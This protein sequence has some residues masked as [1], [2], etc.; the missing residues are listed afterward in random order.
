M[1][2]KLQVRST[3]VH[4]AE[5]I[6]EQCVSRRRER[7]CPAVVQ[8]QELQPP[9]TPQ[10]KTCASQT[11]TPTPKAKQG[12]RRMATKREESDSLSDASTMLSDNNASDNS[13][14]SNEETSAANLLSQVT[15]PSLSASVAPKASAAGS[16]SA[17]PVK[18]NKVQQPTTKPDTKQQPI[19]Q[20]GKTAWKT[21]A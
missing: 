16:S 20:K 7:S 5:D 3:F 19:V 11:T 15:W 8:Q 4:Y 13:K 2:W 9:V 21:N 1:P 10:G 17:W 18:N 14:P 6:S 12:E